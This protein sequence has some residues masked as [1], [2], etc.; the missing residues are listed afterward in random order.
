MK[1]EFSQVADLGNN[2]NKYFKVTF[3]RQ[4]KQVMTDY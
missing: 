3:Y 1:K 4:N 2:V